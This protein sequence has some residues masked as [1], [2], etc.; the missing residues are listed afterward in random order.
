MRAAGV[1]SRP[2]QAAR[3]AWGLARR[4]AGQS[5]LRSEARAGHLGGGLYLLGRNPPRERSELPLPRGQK[6]PLLFLDAQEGQKPNKPL[7]TPLRF[8]AG[9]P[10]PLASHKAQEAEPE[11][12]SSGHPGPAEAWELL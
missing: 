8:P 6:P 4:G 7:P 3:G 11:V 12:P 1:G 5:V 2:P 9:W 10:G